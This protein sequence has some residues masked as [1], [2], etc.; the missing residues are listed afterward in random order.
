M[1]LL[2]ISYED[3]FNVFLESITDYNLASLEE[4]DA[5]LLLKG[6]MKKGLSKSYIK[7]IFKTSTFDDEN[8]IFEFQLKHPSKDETDSEQSEFVINVVSKAMI[9]EWCEPQV[10]KTTNMSQM[11]GGKEQKLSI[12]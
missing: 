1:S 3:I 8:Q 9:I 12:A 6:W 5:F 10:K 4:E 11:F 7:R 2:Q